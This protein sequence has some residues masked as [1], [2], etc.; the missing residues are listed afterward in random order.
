VTK[1][2]LIEKTEKWLLKNNLSVSQ[3]DLDRPWGAFWHITPNSLNH[4][5][6][7]FFPGFDPQSLFI[8]PKILLV[9]PNKRLSLQFHYKRSEKWHVINGPVKIIVDNKE[10]ILNTD[11]N[12]VIKSQQKHRLIGLK[13]SGLVAEIW[14]HN[15]PS[16]P[17][18]ENDIVRLEDDFN[19]ESP[20]KIS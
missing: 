17:S 10:L 13:N 2:K 4:F 16:D 6:D 12:I 5:L 19:R 18:N 8:S 14:M 3:K 9:E 7:L 15:N 20:G 1:L 11:E